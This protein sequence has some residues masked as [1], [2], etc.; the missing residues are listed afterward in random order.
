LALFNRLC[1]A[2]ECP[3]VG[4]EQAFVSADRGSTVGLFIASADRCDG[5]VASHAE[6]RK[7]RADGVGNIGGREVEG[8]FFGRA[9]GRRMHGFAVKSFVLSLDKVAAA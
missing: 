9:D 4:E 6:R 8:I 7:I 3:L 5:G 1:S 2:L